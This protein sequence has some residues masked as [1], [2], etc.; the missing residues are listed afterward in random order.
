MTA[1]TATATRRGMDRPSMQAFAED[2]YSAHEIAEELGYTPAYVR[3][4]AKLYGVILPEHSIDDDDTLDFALAAKLACADELAALRR[5]Y[6]GRSYG[7]TGQRV[8]HLHAGVRRMQLPKRISTI[9][10]MWI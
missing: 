5:E 1:A 3:R 4:R 10:P 8:E 2:G 9:P 6:P 7:S